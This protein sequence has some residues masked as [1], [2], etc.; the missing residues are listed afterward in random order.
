MATMLL[1]Y[2]QRTT[3]DFFIPGRA[4]VET[5]EYNFYARDEWRATRRLTLNV[6]VHY[7]IN[8][9]FT[10]R[11]DY[12]VN[13][14]RA[15]ARLLLAGKN[16][17]RTAGIDTDYGSLGP[18]FGF[19]YQA[20]AKTVVRGGYGIFF[21]PEG[22]HDTTIRQFRQVPYDLIFSIIPGSLIPDNSVSDGFKG[23][24][25]FPPVDPENPSTWPANATLRGVDPGYRNAAVQQF[26]VGV[27][28]EIG[29]HSVVSA[30]YVG[31]LGRHLTWSMPLNQPAPGPGAIQARRP[32][33]ALLPRVT[34]I[35]WIE[36][37]GNSAYNS[38]QLTYEKRFGRGL[39]FLGNWTWAHGLDN[40]GGDGGANGPLPQDP[41]NRRADWG[42]QN[43]DIRHRLNLAWSYTLPFGNPSGKLRYLARDWEIAGI[44]VMQ[45]GLPFT[46][47]ATGSPTNTGAGTRSDVVPGVEAKIDDR[48]INRWF[49]P[50][51]FTFP[52]PYNWGNAG[53]NTLTGPPIYNFDLTLTKNIAFTESRRLIFRTEFFN[54]FNT[55]QFTLPASTIGSTGV[56]TISATARPSR[57]IQFALKLAF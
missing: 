57:Q 29:A 4:F 24:K 51:A 43:S 56:G 6:G 53:R 1:G 55:P 27:Q 31:S 42:S 38:L 37:S 10:E 46:V 32:F 13:F 47:T 28:Q 11:N 48:T 52:R 41:R 49:N 8:T 23:V 16:A 19:A 5:Q 9:P 2:P 20:A 45:S 26:N 14:D 34:N 30:T 12:W 21:A 17:S 15:T 33:A 7:E 40:A 35:S 25:D 36:T 39:Y 50:A 22:R 54:A 3:R 44:T 18:R